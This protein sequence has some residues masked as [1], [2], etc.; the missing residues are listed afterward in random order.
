MQ[1]AP[2]KLFGQVVACPLQLIGREVSM[3]MQYSVLHVTVVK[4]EYRQY[5]PIG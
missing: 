4:Y 3:H 5:A 1:I 2:T